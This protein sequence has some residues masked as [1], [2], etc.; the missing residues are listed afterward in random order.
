MN[1]IYCM[2]TKGVIDGWK[3]DRI[4]M[5]RYM[6]PTIER[7]CDCTIAVCSDMD[8]ADWGK[9][10]A[11]V[12]RRLKHIPCEDG[13]SRWGPWNVFTERTKGLFRLLD[14]LQ[15]GDN[16][17]MLDADVIIQADI[18]DAFADG[19]DIA[20][21]TRKIPE[22]IPINLAVW[23]LRVN[24]KT[25]KFV[26]NMIVELCE[27]TWSKMIALNQLRQH[28]QDYLATVFLN[29]GDFP[30]LK[31]AD[32]GWRYNFCL[33]NQ[34]GAE[35]CLR[36]AINDKSIPIVHL[37]GQKLLMREFCELSARGSRPRNMDWAS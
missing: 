12:H 28:D 24:S 33:P 36:S 11:T 25:R 30:D 37:K 7:H 14:S 35:D 23:A 5:I 27:R 29:Q 15:D 3:G 13:C 16:V 1:Y 2:A 32:L 4:E 21:T 22:R 18:F 19:F 34:P 10:Q 9:L 6:L 17:F 20:F 26:R 8:N 31:I